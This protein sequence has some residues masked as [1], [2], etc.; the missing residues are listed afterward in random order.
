MLTFAT[1]R[2]VLL[3]ALL[4]A[5]GGCSG[6]FVTDPAQSVDLTLSKDVYLPGDTVVVTIRNVGG[7]TLTYAYGFCKTT[8]QRQQQGGQ[9]TDLSVPT[10]GCPFALGILGPG[11]SVPDWYVL[12]SDA[13]PGIYRLTMP[14]PVPKG[15]TVSA[16]D[17]VTPPFSVQSVTL[18]SSR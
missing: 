9:W 7:V 17:V 13:A 10:G 5:A 14:A 2:S 3:T 11:G 8:L 12:A 15:S 16:P 1:R 4:L 6:S 18:S